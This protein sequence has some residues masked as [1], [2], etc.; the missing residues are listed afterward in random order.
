MPKNYLPTNFRVEIGGMPAGYF[1]EVSGIGSEH[2]TAPSATKWEPITLKK[3]YISSDPVG[4]KVHPGDV[5]HKL[6]PASLAHKINP[7]SPMHK[8][9]P[10]SPMHKINPAD[11]MHKVNPRS[12]MHKMSPADPMHK[13]NPGSTM[14]KV[15]PADPMHKVSP[16]DPMHKVNPGSAMPMKA[17][18]QIVLHGFVVDQQNRHLLEHWVNPAAAR[19]ATPRGVI[20]MLDGSGRP[21]SRWN[22]ENAWPVKVS[23]PSM[24]SE[25]TS[26]ELTVTRLTRG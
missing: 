22:F 4:H 9:S 26:V 23:G 21:V 16:A 20:V 11:P 25:G 5:S 7:A 18:G 6:N 17:A 2:A 19:K 14:H 8:V 24:S 13:L 12:A 3:G 1:T 15:S 10:A